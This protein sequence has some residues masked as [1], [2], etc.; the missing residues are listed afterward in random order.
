[1]DLTID[2]AQRFGEEGIGVGGAAWPAGYVLAEYMSRRPSI[3]PDA[4]DVFDWTNKRVVELGAG[5][6]L[7]SIV[8]ALLG[9]DVVATDGVEG[10]LPVMRENVQKHTAAA[11]HAVNCTLLSWGEEAD[12][13]RI[14]ADGVDVVLAADV[15]YGDKVHIWKKL[16]KT[17][18]RLTDPSTMILFGQTKCNTC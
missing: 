13:T 3:P 16:L 1:M 10:V 8:A 12:E 4:D 2:L 17:I 9:A 5:L 18:N 6:G 14:L 15:V 11:K 7:V